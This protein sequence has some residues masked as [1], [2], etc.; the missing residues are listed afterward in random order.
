MERDKQVGSAERCSPPPHLMGR[1]SP[2]SVVLLFFSYL[3][4]AA[5]GK[6]M[7]PLI[8]YPEGQE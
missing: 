8:V 5:V 3:Q 2:L 7:I 4:S 6:Q 1:R